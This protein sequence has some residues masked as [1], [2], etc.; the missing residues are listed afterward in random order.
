MFQFT[1]AC[2]NSLNVFNH[3]C[4]APGAQTIRCRRHE[5]MFTHSI[6]HRMCN[7][8]CETPDAQARMQMRRRFGFVIYSW[9]NTSN[10]FNYAC[11]APAAKAIQPI[12]LYMPSYI[13]YFSLRSRSP[14]R[15]RHIDSFLNLYLQFQLVGLGKGEYTW[16]AED[17]TK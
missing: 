17:Q 1:Y 5:Q 16:Q 14:K 12:H 6:M 3:V 11:G 7:Y 4:G 13:E 9:Y 8:V 10:V 15:K 2:C